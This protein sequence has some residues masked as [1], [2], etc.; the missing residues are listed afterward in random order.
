MPPAPALRLAP[1]VL[2]AAI[3]LAAAPAA[4]AG[5]A[6]P[7]GAFD[8]RAPSAAYPQLQNLSMQGNNAMQSLA[9]E[10][11]AKNLFVLQTVTGKAEKANGDL[12]LNRLDYTGRKID[13]MRLNGFGH[14]VSMGVRRIG[15]SITIVVESESKPDDEG[16]GK[17]S[18]VAA[19]EYHGGDTVQSG[20]APVKDITPPGTE[21][22]AP[23]PTLDP[24]TGQLIVRYNGPGSTWSFLRV[25]LDDALAKQ[26]GRVSVLGR[27]PTAG[28]PRPGDAKSRVT[29]QGYAFAGGTAYLYYGDSYDHVRKPGDA[30]IRAVPMR[31]DKTVKGTIG[32]AD[33]LVDLPFREP[34]GIAVQV[35]PGGAPRLAF[36]FAS[37]PVTSPDETKR[38]VNVAYNEGFVPT[39]V[40][41]PAPA[42]VPAP[43]PTPPPVAAPAPVTLTVKARRINRNRLLRTRRIPISIGG[44]DVAA[45]V[46]VF[47]RSGKRLRRIYT[48][49][50]TVRTAPRTITLR[51][52]PAQARRLRRTR[53]R[54]RLTISVSGPGG[55]ITRVHA[56]V[57]RRR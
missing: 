49:T 1:A 53:G 45:Q 6:L 40:P 48:A 50:K 22:K 3:A 52:S 25:P 4:H 16:V 10:E 55:P 9:F 36:G 38:F 13:H 12:W 7:D 26:W 51:I 23:R 24:V 14:G 31:A 2:V 32:K 44:G 54:V 35:N 47:A 42:P 19:F 11:N 56:T 39:A 46:R 41:A 57:P 43:V 30:Y 17:G 21:N 33:A 37:D 8:P 27:T 34:E 15:K 18:R 5:P 28:E 29:S 20:K